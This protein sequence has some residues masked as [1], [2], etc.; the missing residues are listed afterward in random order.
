MAKGRQ[1]FK[2]VKNFTIGEIYEYCKSH[3]L[4]IYCPFEGCCPCSKM[5]YISEKVLEGEVRID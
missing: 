2:K 1:L 5:K 3:R 4:C